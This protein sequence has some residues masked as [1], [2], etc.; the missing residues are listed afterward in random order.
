MHGDSRCVHG[1]RRSRH[2]SSCSRS[3]SRCSRR[4]H[5]LPLS[6]LRCR[7]H[8]SIRTR[9]VTIEPETVAKLHVTAQNGAFTRDVGRATEPSV[10]ANAQA[11]ASRSAMPAKRPRTVVGTVQSGVS[12]S[13]TVMQPF[14]TAAKRSWR[15]SGVP[16]RAASRLERRGARPVTQ[17]NSTKTFAL[18]STWLAH[19]LG[20]LRPDRR[21]R[22]ERS[23]GS[24]CRELCLLWRTPCHRGG[25][26]ASRHFDA[27]LRRL[28]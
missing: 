7:N 18:P 13:E 11:M 23:A 14:G 28:I 15:A 21:G 8:V 19:P 4:R 24:V 27:V 12:R 22:R 16:E 3:F 17:T 5:G 20:G 6:W 9:A 1:A 25:P 10:R 2:A 26:L